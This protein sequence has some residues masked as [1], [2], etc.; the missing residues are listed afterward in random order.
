[1]GLA[2]LELG[3][4]TLERPLGQGGMGSAWLA[5]RSDGRFEGR[6]A[7]KLMNL[8]HLSPTGQERFRREGTALARPR[9][10][11]PAAS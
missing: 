8:A 6:A 9:A 11:P 5:R 10:A 4:Y 1:V 7:V 2:G 3:G